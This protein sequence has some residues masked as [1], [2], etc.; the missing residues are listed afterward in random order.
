MLTLFYYG[1][2]G[3]SCLVALTNWRKAIYL[4]ILLDFLRD[5]VRK[6]DPSEPVLITISVLGLWGLITLSAWN[7]SREAL[8]EFLYENPK[9]Y[10]AFRLLIFATLPGIAV[11]LA[12]YAEGYKLVA[13]GA[14]SY[15][16]PSAGVLCGVLFASHPAEMNRLLRF[17]CIVN[18]LAL[19]GVVFEYIDYPV[20]ALGGLRGMNWVRYSS[21]EVVNLTAGFYRSPDIMGLHAAHVVMFSLVLTIQARKGLSL[22]WILV[23]LFAG[24]CLL[25]SGRRKML[26]MPLVFTAAFGFF[27][28]LRGMQQ[29][30]NVF[31]PVVG[32]GVAA[33]GVYLVATDEFVADEYTNYASTLFTQGTQRSQEIVIGSVTSTFR[34]TGILGA[35]IGSATQG[36]YHLRSGKGTDELRHGWQED[37]VSRLFREL[38]MVGVFFIIAAGVSLIGAIIDSVRKLHCEDPI[39]YLQLLLYSIVVANLASFIISHQQYSGDPP[40]ALLVLFV[41][42]MALS[43]PTIRSRL[44]EEQLTDESD[45]YHYANDYD[46][47]DG[48]DFDDRNRGDDDDDDPNQSFKISSPR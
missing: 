32:V 20:A 24:F 15:L 26:G 5:P 7:Q 1:L 28:Y 14:V 8:Q 23:A 47:D 10:N 39:S 38:G 12:F 40:S 27:C 44:D 34:Q 19:F 35:G 45:P 18:A 29:F 30:R 41:M 36:A 11:S 33:V 4:A 43:L 48:Y 9:L 22:G 6:L 42:G 13:L 46:D 21:G 25:L 3:V 17:Y 31:I 16:A 2:L 37:G